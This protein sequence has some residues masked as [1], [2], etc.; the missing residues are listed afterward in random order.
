MTVDGRQILNN[1]GFIDVP[2]EIYLPK[3]AFT[4]YVEK[5]IEEKTMQLIE[6]YN[7]AVR[8]GLKPNRD[9]YIKELEK[10]C[11]HFCPVPQMPIFLIGS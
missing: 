6:D 8:C 9:D 2:Y 3:D 5:Q 7:E 11:K 1:N 10:W 4:E